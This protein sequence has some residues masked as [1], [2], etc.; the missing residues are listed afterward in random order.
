MIVTPN[1][2]LLCQFL[3]AHADTGFYH[4]YESEIQ[5]PYFQRSKQ[6]H[7]PT[8]TLMLF[9]RDVGSHSS[10]W[11]KNPD[12][13]RCYHLSLSFWNM[14]PD[15]PQ[16]APFDHKKAEVWVRL[17][18]HPNTNLVWEEPASPT[19]KNEV[20]HYRVF[21]NPA[22]EP[23]MPRKEVYSKDFTPAGWKSWSE[24][25]GEDSWSIAGYEEKD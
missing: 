5:T 16:P 1:M 21:C 11:W 23:I 22:W 4:G 7:A 13:E 24:R 8:G 10:G 19:S 25:T 14:E 3:K 15:E 20:F 2:E 17:F 18:F 6:V 12:Y 9:T